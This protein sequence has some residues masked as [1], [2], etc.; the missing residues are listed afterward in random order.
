MYSFSLIFVDVTRVGYMRSFFQVDKRRTF[1]S[2]NVEK[3]HRTSTSLCVERA[4]VHATTSIS[5]LFALMVVMLDSENSSV[6]QRIH[7][8]QGRG[9]KLREAVVSIISVSMATLVVVVGEK[10]SRRKGK[11]Y[12]RHFNSKDSFS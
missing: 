6:A 1:S 5:E 2:L 12:A 3:S 4:M 7:V 8:R 9:E 10:R 11:K